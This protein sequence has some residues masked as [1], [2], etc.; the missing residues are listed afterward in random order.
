MVHPEE[1]GRHSEALGAE[2]SSV[3]SPRPDPTPPLVS[4]SRS[5]PG[6]DPQSPDSPKRTHRRSEPTTTDVV[7]NRERTPRLLPLPGGTFAGDDNGFPSTGT[8]QTVP[9]TGVDT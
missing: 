2:D 3:Q 7:E 5:H 6:V 9:D 4:P 1:E 8:G